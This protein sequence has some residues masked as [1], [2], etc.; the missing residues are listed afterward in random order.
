MKEWETQN[1]T[2][3]TTLLAT[4]KQSRLYLSG[5]LSATDTDTLLNTFIYPNLE[6][7]VKPYNVLNPDTFADDLDA[8]QST[9]FF[10]QIL[11]RL[12]TLIGG[13]N[14]DGQLL[15]N[16][17]ILSTLHDANGTSTGGQDMDVTSAGHTNSQTDATNEG[18][19][20][21]T[22]SVDAT[23]HTTSTNDG[24]TQAT[25]EDVTGT[26]SQVEAHSQAKSNGTGS[27]ISDKDDNRNGESK[28]DSATTSTSKGSSTGNVDTTGSTTDNHDGNATHGK[29]SG[30]TTNS[31]RGIAE[32]T[33]D[34]SEDH[35]S[36]GTMSNHKDTHTVTPSAGNDVTQVTTSGADTDTDHAEDKGGSTSNTKQTDTTDSSS[37]STAN[38][39]TSTGE[40]GKSHDETQNTNAT[41][42]LNDG[43]T[44]NTGTTNAKG[45]SDS[46]STENSQS[47]NTNNTV[48]KN[49]TKNTGKAN[50][51]NT[52]DTSGSTKTTGNN[53]SENEDHSV[54]INN[55]LTIWLAMA[56]NIGSIYNDCIVSMINFGVLGG[57]Y[58]L[59]DYDR[60]NTGNDSTSIFDIAGWL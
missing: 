29:G 1:Q 33:T 42:A 4:N 50:T 46:T 59:K 12:A 49:D 47:D 15:A 55:S 25:H 9:R 36:D 14:K 31:Y 2:T 45:S 18:E 10:P 40:T 22:G 26:D 39:T 52:G 16:T 58:D 54:S 7:V 3:L 20:N 28:L 41:T 11:S 23:G 5:Q 35:N 48:N 32:T 30:Q 57:V 21:A 51:V 8:W 43:N 13:L 34:A 60:N 37:S 27:S 19:V 6:K 53:H 38:N 44:H 56:N 17:K 24:K